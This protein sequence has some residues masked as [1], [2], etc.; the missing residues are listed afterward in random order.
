MNARV[1]PPNPQ[2][3]QKWGGWTWNG[4]RWACTPLSGVFINV[5]TFFASAPYTPTPGLTS[6]TVECIGPGGPGGAAGTPGITYI[7][8]GGGGG[9]GGY[10][11]KTLAASMV[12]GGVNVTV[13]AGQA[14]S[15][16]ALCIANAGGAGGSNDGSGTE[17]G[18][19]G[20]GAPVGLGDFAVPGAG[21]NAGPFWTTATHLN[22][23]FTGG[24]P[25]SLF[26]GTTL[27]ETGP[28]GASP[29]GSGA[30]GSGAGGQG[31]CVNQAGVSPAV[32]PVQFGGVGGTGACIVTETCWADTG[33][34]GDCGCGP[35]GGAR[36]AWPCPP[37]GWD[38]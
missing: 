33:D 15:F 28:G 1:F 11:R 36:E 31:A 14:T 2:P 30:P 7:V 6:L 5:Q 22:A 32:T 27:L 12:A 20:A 29:G 37:G 38:D 25:G 23:N 16:G 18:G 9:S 3:G 10:S 21:G 24:V 8:G 34:D 17:F 13:A 19:V 26:G 4:S 35:S